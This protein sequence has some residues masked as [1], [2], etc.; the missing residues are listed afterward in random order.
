M[1]TAKLL[2]DY[3]LHYS[4]MSYHFHDIVYR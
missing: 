4:T 3:R 1:V 2:S